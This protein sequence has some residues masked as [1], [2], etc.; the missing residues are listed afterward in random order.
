MAPII[1]TNTYFANSLQLLIEMEHRVCHVT[2][3]V[4]RFRT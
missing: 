2:T 4:L 3:G 1:T